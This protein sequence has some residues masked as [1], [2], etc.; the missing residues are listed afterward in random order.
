M[1][2][3]PH[4]K[5]IDISLIMPKDKFEDTKVVI[6]RRLLIMKKNGNKVQ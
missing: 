1:S 6:R 3:L 2:I 5:W 4:V